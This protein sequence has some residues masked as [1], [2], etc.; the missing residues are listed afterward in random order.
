MSLVSPRILSIAYAAAYAHWWDWK[1]AQE[2]FQQTS[3]K[4]TQQH[5][6]VSC[7]QHFS[8]TGHSISDIQ[9]RCVAL[10]SGSNIQRK[11]REMQLIF[12]LGTFQ[13][14]RLNINFSFIWIGTLYTSCAHCKMRACSDHCYVHGCFSHNGEETQKKP[15]DSFRYLFT[16]YI[17]T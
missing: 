17:H 1:K 15:F 14:K 10:C 9:V 8:S 3:V 12:Q 7:G 2:S 13:L 4:H 6:W 16:E 5:S 11:Q